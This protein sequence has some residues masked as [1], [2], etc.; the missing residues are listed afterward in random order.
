LLERL[1]G[2]TPA[3]SIASDLAIPLDEA[4]EFLEFAVAEGIVFPA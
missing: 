2:T 3:H 1:D 4:R